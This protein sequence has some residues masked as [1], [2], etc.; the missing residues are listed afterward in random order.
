[1]SANISTQN[2]LLGPG[3]KFLSVMIP[4]RSR[5]DKLLDCLR[6]F[7]YQLGPSSSEVEFIVNL[8]SDDTV[9]LSR[10]KELPF[11]SL[12]IKVIV[13]SK[14]GG[15]KD[16]FVFY[17]ECA[18][19]ARGQLLLMW[20][21]DAHFK[22]AQWY[23]MLKSQVMQDTSAYSYWFGGTPSQVVTPGQ[24]PSVQDW[25]CFIAHHRL[26]YQLLGFYGHQGGVDSFLY[27][28]LGPLGLLKKI[29]QIQVDH[30]AWFQIP[31]KERDATAHNNSARGA[32]L[33]TN[34]DVVK[35]CQQRIVE[36]AQRQTPSNAAPGASRSSATLSGPG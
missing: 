19:V 27:Y 6:T 9:T 20:N 14:L 7:Q 29:D 12:D 25:P 17:N 24:S 22:T 26:F 21:D 18:R 10:M 30:L 15:Y 16:L 33:P 31:E 2:L 5:F 35:R 34:Q 1:M 8:D 3:S 28:V 13:S 36:F 23:S 32:M 4:S 11:A